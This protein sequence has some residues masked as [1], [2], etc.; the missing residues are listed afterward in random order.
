MDEQ[1]VNR[2][3]RVSRSAPAR[4]QVYVILRQRIVS[5]DLAPG[6]SLSENELATQLGVSR[7]PVREALIRLAGEGLVEVYPQL[8]TF[9]ARISLEEVR[10]QQFIR[11][12]LERAALPDA[13][14]QVRPADLA[15]LE[16]ILAEQRA[17]HASHDLGRFL[18]AD[19]ALHQA[20]AEIAGH[21]G[22]WRVVQGAKAHL[23]RVRWLSL[24]TPSVI[25]ELVDQHSGIVGGL[26][27]GD[28]EGTDR[29]LTIHLRLVR[30]HLPAIREEHP[31]YFT[32][33]AAGEAEPTTGG[34][35]GT[36]P[37][38]PATPPAAATNPR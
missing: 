3:L 21:P 7:T 9:V 35:A 12:T 6:Q 10:E 29:L 27:R 1:Q 38:L 4:A 32:G 20:I 30:E 2:A 28:L 13:I 24:P 25:G 36:P 26:A 37:A 23:D 31:D 22:I 8:G 34:P 33:E 11:E 15:D 18:A 19:E 16:A 17:A 5:V 14:R